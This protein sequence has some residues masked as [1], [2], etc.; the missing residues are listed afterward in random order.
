MSEETALA[1]IENPTQAM[2]R[3]GPREVI[4]QASEEA[5]ALADVI[6]SQKLY[7]KIQGKKFVKVEGWVTLAA[8]RGC[9][10][11]EVG[12]HK[13]DNGCYTATVE[14]VRMNDGMVLTRAS[15]ECGGPEEDL[16]QSRSPNARHSMAITRATGKACRIAFSWVMALAGYQPTPL[17]EMDGV[18]RSGWDRNEASNLP[19]GHSSDGEGRPVFRGKLVKR[20]TKE[21]NRKDGSKWML[22]KYIAY[23]GSE[24]GTFSGTIDEGLAPL[25]GSMVEITWEPTE[26]GGKDILEYRSLG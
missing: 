19:G 11:K 12:I 5:A 9:L 3:P 26:K 24:F 18:A 20:E 21:G 17:E 16:W 22:Y 1:I 8:L 14:L 7:S 6:E 23:E 15:A 4:A 2:V 13:D 25:V 10:P